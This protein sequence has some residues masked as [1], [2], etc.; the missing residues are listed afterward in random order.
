MNSAKAILRKEIKNKLKSLTEQE[1]SRQSDIIVKKLLKTPQYVNSQRLSVYLHMKNEVQTYEILK[2]ALKSGKNV[3]VPKYVKT[4]MDMVKLYSLKDYDQLPVTSWHI[5]Q[6]A[7]DDVSRENA[8]ESGG[9]DLIIVPGV[10]F[11]LTGDR[12]G[13]GKG[14]YDTY[15]DKIS[16]ISSPYLIGLG[17]DVQIC[18]NIPLSDNDK[19]LDEVLTCFQND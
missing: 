4:N 17:F 8:V 5:K 7:D 9:L 11:S 14:Y 19:P 6:P 1:K 12:M 2:H 3:Y 18:D 10:A 16:K 13:H 15:I